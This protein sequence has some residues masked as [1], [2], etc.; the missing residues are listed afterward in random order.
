[1][2]SKISVLILSYN[3]E[4][5]IERCINHIYPIVE[6]I[7]I[8]DS[9]SNDRTLEIAKKYDKVTVL[10]NKWENQ[11]AKQFNWGLDNIKTDS[12]W[13]LRLDADEYLLPELI[14]E[15]KERLDD[16]DETISGIVFKRRHY[17]LD[18]WMKRGIYPVKMIR[19][20]RRNKGI[21]EQRLMDEHIQ[22]S[23]GDT[24]EFNH[25][26]V[27]HNLNN[28]SW[29][30]QKHIGYAIREA[31]DLLD[32]ELGLTGEGE[33]DSNKNIDD[34][35]MKKRL[36][37][38]KYCKQPLFVRSFVYF[39]YRYFF[40]MGFL[41]GKEGF[42]WNFLQGWW[43]RTLVDVKIFEIKKECGTDKQKIKHYLS[44]I[45]KINI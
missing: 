35:A 1:M 40:K 45:Y 25:D 12:D 30:C 37:K 10:Q 4:L 23:E 5:H 34:Q 26:F 17:F 9:F 22:L 42:I 11:Y 15:I 3:E 21:C 13:I 8:I 2:K 27:D 20:F 31:A 33:S 28:I 38:H 14:E 32:I 44:Q 41:E 24:M 43:Y 39:I 18:K 16:I 36:I 6:E 29:F 7:F 19:L